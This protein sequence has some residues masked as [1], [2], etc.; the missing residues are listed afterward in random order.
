MT[1][2]PQRADI[3]VRAYRYEQQSG[4][5]AP[6]E[7]LAEHVTWSDGFDH[8]DPVIDAEDFRWMHAAECDDGR[9]IHA[10]EQ[11]LTGCYLHL[12]EHGDA[13]RYTGDGDAYCYVR[14]NLLAA[15]EHVYDDRAAMFVPSPSSAAP[16]TVVDGFDAERSTLE[17]SVEAL[18]AQLP[19]T[20]SASSDAV[21]VTVDIVT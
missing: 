3:G 20:G 5:W 1:D 13:Y 8:P 18:V 14:T 12:D 17:R 11:H 16:A 15:V 2:T 7:A 19:V 4:D 6:F 9:T 21:T 10:Y